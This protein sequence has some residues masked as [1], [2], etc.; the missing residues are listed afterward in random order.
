MLFL[1]GDLIEAGLCPLKLPR[2]SMVFPAEDRFFDSLE[3]RHALACL[4][5]QSG[6]RRYHLR[7]LSRSDETEDQN[8][9]FIGAADETHAAAMQL[10]MAVIELV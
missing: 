9:S 3:K 1:G 4:F 2:C 6:V 10:K 7:R 5:L 8:R